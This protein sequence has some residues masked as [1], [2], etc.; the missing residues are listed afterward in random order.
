MLALLRLANK[1]IGDTES[2]S[3]NARKVHILV[4]PTRPEVIASLVINTG[5]RTYHIELRA[6]ERTY[7]AS[8]PW[9]RRGKSRGSLIET[10]VE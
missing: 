7:M 1:P 3:G 8:V 9:I 6:S 10:I 4:K 2:G 5:Q